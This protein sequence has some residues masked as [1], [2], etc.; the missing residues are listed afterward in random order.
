MRLVL[1][2][3]RGILSDSLRESPQA[4]GPLDPLGPLDFVELLKRHPYGCRMPSSPR[5]FHS[6][7]ESPSFY[8]G[9]HSVAEQ[10]IGRMPE[11]K[12]DRINES[13]RNLFSC[14]IMIGPFGR[15]SGWKKGR[16]SFPEEQGK[17]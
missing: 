16:G 5:G 6:E 7:A 1:P 11:M 13:L 2:T 8:R 17:G 10:P 15:K 3:V 9:H 4:I 12:I 14:L